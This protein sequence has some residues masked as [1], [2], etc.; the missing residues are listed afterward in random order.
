MIFIINNDIEYN[1]KACMLTHFPTNDSLSLSIS[2]GRLLEMLLTSEGRILP[3]EV[4]LHAVWDKYGLTGSNNNLNQY[5]SLIWRALAGFDCPSF[6]VT[7]S[8]INTDVSVSIKNEADAIDLTEQTPAP[9]EVKKSSSQPRI[10]RMSFPVATALFVTL[11]LGLVSYITS[12]LIDKK[13]QEIYLN[14]TQ[15]DWRV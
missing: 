9:I 14:Y 5:L 7:A 8:Q 1:T 6:I 11:T 10:E 2:S 12:A 3:R 13:N 15:L 4:I